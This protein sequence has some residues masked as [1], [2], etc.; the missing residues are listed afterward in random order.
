MLQALRTPRLSRAKLNSTKPGSRCAEA[1][2]RAAEEK[3]SLIRWLRPEFQNPKGAKTATQEELAASDEPEEAAA[4]LPTT[5]TAWP[6]KPP[7]QIAAIR[8]LVARTHEAWTIDKACA[9]FKGAKK[10][11][12]EEVLESLEALGLRTGYTHQSTRRWKAALT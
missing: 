3:R 8:D 7:E 5:G 4:Q 2:E 9:G 11:D 10:T 1:R 6:K 12:V